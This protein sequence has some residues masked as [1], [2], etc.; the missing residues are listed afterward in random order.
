VIKSIG[1]IG[2][3]IICNSWRHH[4]FS[5]FPAKPEEM[6]SITKADN[7]LVNDGSGDN[8][9]NLSNFDDDDDDSLIVE[10][11]FHSIY[12]FGNDKRLI[13]CLKTTHK[14]NKEN[15]NAMYNAKI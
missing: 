10:S 9:D 4:G 1:S 7:L 8:N 15:K 2:P 12:L 13:V 5:Y 14:I 6:V 3:K 11:P